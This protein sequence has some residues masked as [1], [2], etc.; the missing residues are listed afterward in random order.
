MPAQRG[1]VGCSAAAAASTRLALFRLSGQ[2]SAVLLWR[3]RGLLGLLSQ[4]DAE[5]P[6]LVSSLDC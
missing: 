5:L 6:E 1:H 3:S 2:A 4:L